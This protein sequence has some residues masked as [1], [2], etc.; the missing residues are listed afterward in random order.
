MNRQE[1][2]K[3]DDSPDDLLRMQDHWKM[4]KNY[5]VKRTAMNRLDNEIGL[6]QIP[7][8]SSPMNG[9]KQST[10]VKTITISIS[11]TSQTR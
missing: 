3:G 9:W 8:R 11:R 10:R 1:G 7:R 4:R 5:N 6:I 2:I